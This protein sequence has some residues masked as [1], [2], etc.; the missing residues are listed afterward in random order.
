MDFISLFGK[1]Y[2]VQKLICI[3]PEF[4]K[5]I[6]VAMPV[7]CHPFKTVDNKILSSVVTKLSVIPKVM[8]IYH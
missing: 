8:S 6:E 4:F 1:N 7:P 5:C 2:L 3:I